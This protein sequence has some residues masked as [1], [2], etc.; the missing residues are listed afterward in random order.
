MKSKSHLCLLL[1]LAIGLAACEAWKGTTP[2]NDS[3]LIIAIKGDDLALDPHKMED[4]ESMMINRQI[5]S[6]LF[7]YDVNG[8]IQNDL[9]A[10]WIQNENKFTFKLAKRTFSNGSPILAKDIKRSFERLFLLGS[11]MGSDMEYI[12][13]VNEFRSKKHPEISGINVKSEFEVEFELTRPSPLFFKH[14]A[15]SDCA[16]VFENFSLAAEPIVTSGPY[17]VLKNSRGDWKIQKWRESPDDSKRPP[18]FVGFKTVDP[19]KIAT[20]SEIQK[21]DSLDHF[22]LGAEEIEK[23]LKKGWSQ[24]LTA[25]VSEQFLILNP[26]KLSLDLRSIVF[27]KVSTEEVAKISGVRNA[28]PAYGLIPDY[29]SGHL[30]KEESEKFPVTNATVPNRKVRLLVSF[31]NPALVKV[32]DYLVATL[33]PSGVDFEVEKVKG[34]EYLKRMFAGDFEAVLGSKGLDYPDAFATLSYMRSGYDSNYFLIS[35]KS[36]DELLDKASIEADDQ[37][38]F[39]LYKA[40]Q[41]LV[42]QEKVVLPL[43]FGSTQSG[44]W[45]SKLKAVPPHPMGI[46]LMPMASLELN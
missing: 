40:I 3:Q 45:S 41:K 26:K 36:V 1:I 25:L 21:V 2:M 46:H 16:A 17:K 5:H 6:G 38:R 27:N 34:S 10:S 7:S 31:E 14:L 30:T 18:Q 22:V 24:S 20:D 12:L 8:K 15:S 35:N 28:K 9:V 23:F 43:F 29:L 11:S 13:G 4:A 39:E 32:A 44:L 37:R 42:L 33:K 19:M